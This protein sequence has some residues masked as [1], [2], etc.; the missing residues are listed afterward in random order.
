MPSYHVSKL[1]DTSIG[2]GCRNNGAQ[3]NKY[4]LRDVQSTH[5]SNC[6]NINKVY[7]IYFLTKGWRGSYCDLLLTSH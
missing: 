6:R 5:L 4:G 2:I 1:Y 7:I 3:F